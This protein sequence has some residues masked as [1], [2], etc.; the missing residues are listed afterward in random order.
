MF[1]CGY[2]KGFSTKTVV[3]NL[4]KILGYRIPTEIGK[5]RPG[6]I[7]KIVANSNKFTKNFKWKPKFNDLN[8]ILSTAVD[9]EKKLKHLKL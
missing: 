7:Q 1:N 6:D 2:G 8:F 9:W 4:N 5:R 3:K